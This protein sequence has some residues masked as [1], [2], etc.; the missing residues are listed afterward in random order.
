MLPGFTLPSFAKI[1]WTL[2]ILGRRVDGFHELFTIFQ[3]VTLHDSLTFEASDKLTLTCNLKYLPRDER[4]SVIKAAKILQGRFGLDKGGA[5]HLEKRIPTPG[6][7]GGGS[8]NAAVALM[9]LTR[10]WGID[11]DERDLLSMASELGSDAPFFLY[12]GTAIGTGR[13]EIIEPINDLEA[14]FLVIVT[15]KVR[16]STREAFKRIDV[17]TLTNEALEHILPVCRLEAEL[18]DL[19][20]S[21]LKNDFEKSVFISFPEIE[22]V[23]NTLFELGAVNAAM[24]GSGASVFAVFDKEETWQAAQKALGREVNW[25]KFVVS[26]V[27]RSAYRERLHL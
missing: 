23:K 4:N 13:G 9:G 8:S 19:H 26:T 6:G 2:R 5:I 7:L 14:K 10:L 3:T 15:P 12:G 24:S 27:G 1:N 22:R 20:D 11:C 18:L 16:V 17:A 21:A 25:R